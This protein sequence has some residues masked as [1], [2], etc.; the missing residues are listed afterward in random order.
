MKLPKLYAPVLIEFWSLRCGIGSGYGVV[1]DI[2]TKVFRKCMRVLSDGSWSWQIVG[3]NNLRKRDY[4]AEVDQEI[5]TDCGAD[6]EF[7]VVAK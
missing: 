6:I 2:D 5:L 4:L 7:S 1:F 3:Y